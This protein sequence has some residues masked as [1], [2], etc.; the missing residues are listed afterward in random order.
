VTA[1]EV[2]ADAAARLE[3]TAAR[4]DEAMARVEA[5]GADER[6]VLTDVLE[7]LDGLHRDALTV[8]VR[9]LR[10]DDR[11]RELLYALVDEP[12]VRMVLS[13]HGIIRPDPLTLATR[14]LEGVRPHL[15]AHGGDVELD[16][17]EDGV[18]YVRLHGACTGCSMAAVTLRDSVEEA[19]RG[20]VP[21]LTGVEVVPNDPS[22]TLIPV[23]SLTVRPS[24]DDAAEARALAAAG[25]RDVAP[26]TDL[27]DG[28]V[29]AVSVDTADGRS[30][31]VVLV[32]AGGAP[33]AYLNACAHQG[34]RLDGALVDATEGTITCPWHGLC[35]DVASGECLTLQGAQLAPVPLRVAD[36]RL[37]VRP[38]EG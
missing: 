14:A 34:R 4:L 11:G 33:A 12:E 2:E 27:A 3:R 18:A 5:L 16:R 7:C 24:T 20:G 31:D 25:W 36:G 32:R 17:L 9:R 30:V 1:P 10:E 23:E 29:R 38:G 8:V 21:G 19:L 37:W 26:V 35:Y 6:A 13:M 15:A 28:T 22:P